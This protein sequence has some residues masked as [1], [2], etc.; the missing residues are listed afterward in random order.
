MAITGKATAVI[1][2]TD[3]RAGDMTSARDVLSKK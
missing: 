1:D 2:L 3:Q